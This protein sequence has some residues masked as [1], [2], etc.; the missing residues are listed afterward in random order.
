MSET[1]P[2]PIHFNEELL[3]RPPLKSLDVVTTLAHFAIVT[4]AVAPERV[5][6]HIHPQFELDGFTDDSGRQKVCVSA[7]PFLDTDFRF[8][9]F[10]WLKFR[11]GQT[12]YRTYV[13]DRD[14]G[15]RAV[16]FWG[17]SLDS[18]SVYIPRYCWQLP[19]HRGKIRFDCHYDDIAKRYDRYR[20]TTESD[21]AAVDLELEDSG[22]PIEHIEG[23]D[24]LES[25][26]VILTH[27]LQGVFYRRDGK[28]GTYNI[29][30]DRLQCT[31]GAIR[32]ARFG[33]FDRLGI[34][35][36]AEQQKAHSVL[37]QPSTEF[38]IYLPPGKYDIP[39]K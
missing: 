39:N 3:T 16:W 29:W 36:F 9:I 21:W 5:R 8:M 2:T 32:H 35:P 24:S 19:W 6:P 23:Y 34:V 13:R 1:D 30:H 18:L 7:V 38:S 11:F 12:N 33:L 22:S 4:Y 20:M 25:A 31:S 37:I 14:T 28:L 26:M 27:P 10:P 17:T 15:H